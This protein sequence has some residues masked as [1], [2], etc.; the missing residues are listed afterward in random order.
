MTHMRNNNDSSVI[1]LHDFYEVSYQGGSSYDNNPLSKIRNALVSAYT[2]KWKIPHSVLFLLSDK[3]MIKDNM[4][5]QDGPNK[6][7][8]WLF[9]EF[10]RIIFHRRQQLPSKA[11]PN[12]ATRMFVVGF[13]PVKGAKEQLKRDKFNITLQNIAKEKDVNFLLCNSINFNDQS[14]Y[15]GQGSITTNGMMKF[16]KEISEAVNVID[17]R[18]YAAYQDLVKLALA[19]K[20]LI[21]DTQLF[22]RHTTTLVGTHQPSFSFA[23]QNLVITSRFGNNPD[24]PSRSVITHT[25]RRETSH[26]DEV[27][28]NFHR[29]DDS[30]TSILEGED[31][32]NQA[33]RRQQANND[34]TFRSNHNRRGFW[35]R[36]NS[37]NKNRQ[38]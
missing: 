36:K 27:N 4:I 29:I 13:L 2:A 16:W 32:Y 34:T 37:W 18:G 24:A 5:I 26:R 38:F 25:G 20:E 35:R 17:T 11:L 31:W 3:A 28:T 19:Q 30:I 7:I 1:H 6:I 21:R 12:F 33:H 15:D 23:D 9:D 14:S 8:K 10:K 22:N